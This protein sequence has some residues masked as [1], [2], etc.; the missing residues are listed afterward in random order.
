MRRNLLN[1]RE[2]ALSFLSICQRAGR[3]SHG[4]FQCENSVGS[5]KAKLL[6][7]AEDASDNTVKKFSN[8]ASVRNIKTVRFGTK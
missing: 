1:N 4:E 2:R 6:I 7:I 8:L 3:L 5:G